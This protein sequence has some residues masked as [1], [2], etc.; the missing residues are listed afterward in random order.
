MIAGVGRVVWGLDGLN[1][2]PRLLQEAIPS[3]GHKL[4][5]EPALLAEV[6]ADTTKT[7]ELHSMNPEYLPRVVPVADVE[8]MARI[9]WALTARGGIYQAP[10]AAA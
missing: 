10:V 6:F 1:L 2:L 3:Y 9:V 4:S 7:L 8:W 5:E